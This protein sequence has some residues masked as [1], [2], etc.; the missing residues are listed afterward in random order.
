MGVISKYQK[1][2]S[3]LISPLNNANFGANGEMDPTELKWFC[4]I[5]TSI[6]RLHNL[7][8]LDF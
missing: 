6:P 2:S 3:G 4:L 1:R 8:W 7:T 5:P